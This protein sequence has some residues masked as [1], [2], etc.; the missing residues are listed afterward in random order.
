[1]TPDIAA[2]PA[3]IRRVWRHALAGVL[4]AA[5]FLGS[6]DLLAQLFLPAASPLLALGS[7][8]I[9]FAPSAVQDFVISF[10]GTANRQV[11]FLSMAIGGIL[12]ASGIGLLA[13]RHLI[14]GLAAYT[15]V[16]AVLAAAVVRRP[17]TSGA[18]IVPVIA[19]FL[20]GVGTLVMLCRIA[21]AAA[22]RTAASTTEASSAAGPESAGAA[23]TAPGG[24]ASSQTSSR[25][26]FL[27]MAGGAT[28]VSAA[29][30]A[31][32]RSVGALGRDMG[33][34]VARMVLPTPASPADPIP[35][36]ASVGV[37]GVEPYLTPNS[38]FYRIDT[39][40]AV[41]ELEPEEWTLR[42]HGLVEEEVVIDMAELL[43]LPM[44][45]HHVTLACV[46]NAVGGDLIGNAT[47][48][49]YPVREL[50]DRARPLPEADMVLSESIDG[51]TAS[52]PLEVL[53]DDRAS[54]LAVGMNGE[55][56]PRAHGYPAR[57]VVPGL[58]GYVSAT[59]W[60][61]ELKVTRFDE[62]TA[63]WTDRGWDER[64]PV[65]VSSRIDVPGSLEEV[66]EGEVVIAGSAWA[67]HDGIEA[68][69]VSIDG[70]DWE[71]AELATEV[72]IDTWRQWRYDFS[73]AEPGRHSATVRAI[74]ASGETQTSE[75]TDPIPNAAT[76]QH[77][78]EFS[79]S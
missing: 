52:T 57:L 13:R 34:R 71:D 37:D 62:E 48:L 7:G 56:L 24:A 9:E 1:M 79:V 58:Y 59:K 47:W 75:R 4:A 12:I 42:I 32:G 33:E 23:T 39:A 69:Q 74:T 11:L 10:F 29:T 17:E 19:G 30:I 68:V 78:I 18:D 25:R 36:G 26:L 16:G 6:A 27:A 61:V 15:L 40:L 53:T 50:L 51:F 64:A 65:L 2:D 72:T 38:D 66:P 22:P 31:F 60:V 54:L 5:V 45:E 44:E 3:W 46:S 20:L 77:R 55:P 14:S 21:A 8:V 28:V 67:M 70:G 76:G 73:D 49:G 35:D 63:Y 43:E 41:P